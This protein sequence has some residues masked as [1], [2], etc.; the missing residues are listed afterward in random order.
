VSLKVNDDVNALAW[1][2]SS[3]DDLL[4][5]T[6]DNLIQCDI[7]KDWASKFIDEGHNKRVTS[8]KFDT[9]DSRG[10]RFATLSQE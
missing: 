8:I 10:E 4:V 2:P 1:L 9:Y 3:S 7:R 6:E 5:A